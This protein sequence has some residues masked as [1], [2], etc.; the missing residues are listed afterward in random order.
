MT[1]AI[2]DKVST[3]IARINLRPHEAAIG[4]A[5]NV[6]ALG[7]ARFAAR[8]DPR[9]LLGVYTAAVSPKA[10]QTGNFPEAMREAAHWAVGFLPFTLAT[11]LKRN[12]YVA[13]ASGGVIGSLWERPSGDRAAS[14]LDTVAQ[15][16]IAAGGVCA[17]APLLRK[18]PEG[19]WRGFA[20]PGGVSLA[21]SASVGG[22]PWLWGAV[23]APPVQAH[24]T[25]DQGLV[26]M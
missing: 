9:F 4:A 10:F 19:A 26:F 12:L 2:N 14:P 16:A 17:A 22:A 23:P 6:A 8:Y 1:L 7:A 18:I 13:C 24:A 20:K 21:I 11:A 15:A 25:A 5:W 3:Q